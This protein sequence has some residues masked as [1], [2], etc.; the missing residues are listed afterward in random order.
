MASYRIYP[1]TEII[2]LR[3]IHDVICTYGLFSFLYIT[4]FHEI[5]QNIHA[6]VDKHLGHFYFLTL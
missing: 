4:L 5:L 2:F 3:V 1:F 6:T